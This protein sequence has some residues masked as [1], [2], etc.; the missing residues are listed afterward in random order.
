[1]NP[2]KRKEYMK[3]F[4]KKN[5]DK[6]REKQKCA[7]CGGTYTYFNKAKHIKTEK[8]LYI[9]REMKEKEKYNDL[10]NLKEDE[11]SFIN[12]LLIKLKENISDDLLKHQIDDSLKILLNND[13]DII[14]K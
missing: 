5:D 2:E 8:H 6:I 11:H 3:I 4:K 13:V 7:I 12:N 9:E 14:I 10:K 1:M